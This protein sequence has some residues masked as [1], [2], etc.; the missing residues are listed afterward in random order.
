MEILKVQKRQ[1]SIASRKSRFIKLVVMVLVVLTMTGC[2]SAGLDGTT[3][4]LNKRATQNIEY[5]DKIYEAGLISDELSGRLKELINANGQALSEMTSEA[6]AS[7]VEKIKRYISRAVGTAGSVLGVNRGLQLTEEQEADVH[8]YPMISDDSDAVKE[9]LDILDYNVYVLRKDIKGTGQGENSIVTMDMVRDAVEKAKQVEAKGVGSVDTLNETLSKYFIKT[10]YKVWDTTK[11]ENKI[12]K[13]TEPYSGDLITGCPCTTDGAGPMETVNENQVHMVLV[14]TT[15]HECSKCGSDN[16]EDL[17]S[18]A[19]I[20]IKEFNGPAIERLCGGEG[21]NKDRF[22][23]IGTNCYL[24]EYPVYYVEGFETNDNMTYRANYVQSD[25]VINLLT[26]TIKD[27]QGRVCRS[28][29]MGDILS[30]TGD[31]GIKYSETGK[32]SF[33]TDGFM[34]LPPK[35]TFL[36]P[37]ADGTII[38]E[39]AIMS[40][41]KEEQEKE[42]NSF[43]GVKLLAPIIGEDTSSS[44]SSGIPQELIEEH[45]KY[46]RVILRDYLE[47]SYMPTVVENEDLVA[48][49]RRVR[50]TRFAGNGDEVIGMFITKGGEQFPESMNIKITDLMDVT[51]GFES[52][53]KYKLNIKSN[54]EETSLTENTENTNSDDT[55]TEDNT[56]TEDVSGVSG[57]N[58]SHNRM[59]DEVLV[60]KII[61]TTRF[62]GTIIDRIDSIDDISNLGNE[63]NPD[64]GENTEET[65]ETSTANQY[66][67][68]IKHF[69]YGMGIDVDPFTSNMYSGWITAVD[70]ESGEGS[71]DWWNA[72]LKDSSYKYRVDK[73]ALLDFLNGRYSLEMDDSNTIILDIQTLKNI[74]KEYIADRQQEDVNFISTLFVVLSF[75]LLAYAVLLMLAWIYDT[76]IIAGPRLMKFITA[77]RMEAIA[78]SEEIPIIEDKNKRYMTFQDTVRASSMIMFIG[79]ILVFVDV[80]SIVHI[81]V[82]LFGGIAV[83]FSNVIKAI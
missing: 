77:G 78:G 81:L 32:A 11:D 63:D 2:E 66:E 21:V 13:E 17:E 37:N 25:Y 10:S 57:V 38:S 72:W 42:R 5:V 75:I 54:G 45:K 23:I 27:S 53:Q 55:D 46:G 49:G 59:L 16:C 62:P 48:V 18:A 51:K 29:T 41:V 6:N 52:R 3:V 58:V 44:S 33:I 65:N 7:S 82:Q 9:L 43:N 14:G 1:K 35:D 83:A 39:S 68:G 4:E 31:S 50:L 26:N 79:V 12:I 76:N 8:A 74:T 47:L 36:R 64:I 20:K 67:T 40:M 30:V 22:V 34:G 70:S 24:M 61:T 80:V 56:D 28:G 60:D 19:E 71:L 73:E 15:T 69:F